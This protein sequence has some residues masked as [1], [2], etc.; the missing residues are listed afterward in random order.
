MR[1]EFIRSFTTSA[2]AK[3]MELGL[4]ARGLSEDFM[5]KKIA[6]TANEVLYPTIFLVDQKEKSY[7]GEM[8]SVEMK[9]IGPDRYDISFTS[10]KDRSVLS[11]LERYDPGWQL[12]GFEKNHFRINGYANGWLIE[13]PGSYNQILT[14]IPQ[15]TFSIG[16]KVT[17]AFLISI[18][19]VIYRTRR[20]T[21]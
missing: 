21:V 19:I 4:C 12:S 7:V 8:G 11:F 3:G 1:E 5:K 16:V 14:F 2:D 10:T 17:V 13:K 9:K 18:I 15:K 6:L 20:G